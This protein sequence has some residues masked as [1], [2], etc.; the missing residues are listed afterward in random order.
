[1]KMLH[2]GSCMLLGFILQTQVYADTTIIFQDSTNKRNNQGQME[3]SE[4]KIRSQDS[5][6]ENTYVIF[7][8]QS[9]KFTVVNGKDRT[10][11]VFGQDEIAQLADM[12]NQVMKQMEQQ[13]SQLPAAQREQMKQMMSSMPG[14]DA[15]KK[16][17]PRRYERGEKREVAGY[18][19]VLTRIYSGD[20]KTSELCIASPG[21][22]DISRS[23]FKTLQAFQE[24]ARDLANN[25]A[26]LG[27]GSMDFGVPEQE[28]IPIQYVRYTS[29]AGTIKGQMKSVNDNNI[30]ASRFEIPKNYKREK[31][32]NLE[33]MF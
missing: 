33:D 24:F 29:V 28:G 11:M 10:Y 27:D 15:L 8:A 18:D 4:G 16:P 6:D 26:M 21:E 25:V 5:E 12:G 19:C 32:P 20:K 17:E 23:D 22:L 13:L 31:L 1:M 14:M 2:I 7:D 9:D 3:I 30:A